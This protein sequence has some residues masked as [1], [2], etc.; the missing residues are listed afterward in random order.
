MFGCSRKSPHPV[1]FTAVDCN[2]YTTLRNDNSEQ[3]VGYWRQLSHWTWIAP[4]HTR[5]RQRIVGEDCSVTPERPR[6][7][8]L[9]HRSAG[10]VLLLSLRCWSI[11][12]IGLLKRPR[13]VTEWQV[14]MA[15]ERMVG[16]HVLGEPGNVVK[17]RIPAAYSI[18]RSDT[19][20]SPVNGGTSWL[21][22]WF[23]QH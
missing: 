18:M 6:L 22:T 8:D 19:G 15:P 20:P 10:V 13:E 3:F 12:R 14:D 23:C 4:R 9:L 5:H 21:L 7:M 11:H 17:D 1:S 2:Y 16:W